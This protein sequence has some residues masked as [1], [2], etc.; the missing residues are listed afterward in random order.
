[1]NEHEELFKK[2]LIFL[3]SQIKAYKFNNKNDAA[4]NDARLM[5]YNECL[6]REN[7]SKA[8]EITKMFND[9][10]NEK[11]AIHGERVPS[12]NSSSDVNNNM[13][14]PDS[15]KTALL[16]DVSSDVDSEASLSE[17]TETTHHLSDIGS[18]D[19]GLES[20][21]STET[22]AEPSREGDVQD[23]S[24]LPETRKEDNLPSETTQDSLSRKSNPS[25]LAPC[26]N[27]EK[28]SS[29]SMDQDL[30][31]TQLDERTVTKDKGAPREESAPQ[32]QIGDNKPTVA[33]EKSNIIDT[34][35]MWQN[36]PTKKNTT[37]YKED[38]DSRCID[39]DAGF[40][41]IAA[42]VRGRSHAHEG[43]PRD[44]DFFIRSDSGWNVLAVADGA[45]SCQFSRAGS[46]IAAK[47]AV[48]TLC[49]KLKGNG[50]ALLDSYPKN[51][52][53]KSSQE[54]LKKLQT[55][56]YE[57]LV[58]STYSACEAIEKEAVD[59]TKP[60]KDFSTTLLLAAHRKTD[61]GHMVI[62]F[63]VGDGAIVLYRDGDD[64]IMLGE[65]DG[66]EYAGQTRF[67]DERIFKDPSLI[68][69]VGIKVVENF[70]ALILAT[71]GITDPSFESDAELTKKQPWDDLWKSAKWSDRS[72]QEIISTSDRNLAE[73]ELVNWSGFFSKGNHDDRTIAV[74]TNIKSGG[75]E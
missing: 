13:T 21:K 40:R 61:F 28:M 20:S 56:L 29:P 27:E 32:S 19:T 53:E 73:Q 4:A 45:G 16:N 34:Q 15:T 14:T 60:V 50:Q 22:E 51:E 58:K 46:Q 65:P 64:P 7:L 30:T 43:T 8:N 17:K 11:L 10:L 42:S 70:T 63:W 39:A 49:E 41:L 68:K 33:F 24:D 37:Y 66:G 5:S 3:V 26:T 69:R 72:L 36:I 23:D 57:I 71:D 1:M 67:L 74:L 38:T 31:M 55:S 75:N 44:D 48:K 6:E 2:L 62:S 47:T 25:F 52:E 35:S 12:T 9:W 59:S 18:I 54:Q